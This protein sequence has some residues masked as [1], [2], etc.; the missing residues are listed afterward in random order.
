MTAPIARHHGRTT[1]QLG[2]GSAVEGGG[3]HEN[4]KVRPEER[5]R[6]QGESQTEVGIQ[7]ALVKLI[8]QQGAYAVQRRVVEQH[9]CEHALGDDLDARGCT[10]ARLTAH[11]KADGVTGQLAKHRGHAA[12][13]GA[14]GETTGLE[15]QYATALQPGFVEQRQRNACRFP[16]ARRSLEHR[17]RRRCEHGAE[18]RQHVRDGQRGG[19]RRERGHRIA[20]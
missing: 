19:E 16:R 18:F 9:P 3:H 2:D 10:H 11:A 5:L 6:L 4:S 17:A 13:S 8:E 12:C 7:A 20:M 14:R 15:H 1:K